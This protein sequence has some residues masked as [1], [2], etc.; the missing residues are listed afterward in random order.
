MCLRPA[1]VI[2]P[3]GCSERWGFFS[4]DN[5]KGLIGIFAELCLWD[6]LWL[7][8]TGTG[9][10]IS[11]FI[12]VSFS[13]ICTWWSSHIHQPHWYCVGGFDL[14]RVKDSCGLAKLAWKLI[15]RRVSRLLPVGNLL[16]HYSAHTGSC[17]SLQVWEDREH[18]GVSTPHQTLLT[19]EGDQSQAESLWFSSFTATPWTS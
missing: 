4:T 10:N 2:F 14:D 19:K 16:Q 1:Q 5:M 6:P 7:S 17:T 11:Y 9:V 15:P 13:E 8:H 18:A 3:E 12:C